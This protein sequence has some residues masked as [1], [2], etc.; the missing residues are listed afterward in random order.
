MCVDLQGCRDCVRGDLHIVHGYGNGQ[1]WVKIKMGG[2]DQIIFND[3]EKQKCF[4]C[5]GGE[6]VFLNF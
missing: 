4:C 1:I 6:F 5:I 3:D 2:M